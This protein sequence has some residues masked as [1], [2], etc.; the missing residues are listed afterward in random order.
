[1]F[2]DHVRNAKL[3]LRVTGQALVQVGEM[4]GYNELGLVGSWLASVDN[5]FTKH[6]GN[7]NPN[8]I[9]ED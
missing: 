3:N 4:K 2:V 7:M 5:P 1:M 6:S 8:H 9:Y